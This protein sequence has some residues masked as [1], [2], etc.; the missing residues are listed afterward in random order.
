LS[1]PK[2]ASADDPQT[3]F[4]KAVD[5][6]DAGDHAAARDVLLRI[7]EQVP[8]HP[9]I[10]NYLGTTTHRTG[11][12]SSAREYF[13]R[14]VA[15]RPDFEEAWRNLGLLAFDMGDYAG[16]A[17]ALDRLCRLAPRDAQARTW[18]A[19]ALQAQDRCADAVAAYERA[20]E[21]NPLP[22]DT[23]TKMG[24]ALLWE[25]RWD[26]AC[27]AT[28]R[29]LDLR[30]G[31]TGALAL[32]SV[33]LA[34][35]G[36]RAEW[37][38]IVDFDRLLHSCPVPVPAGYQD[39][40]T[41]NEALS[42]YCLG[43]PTL[44]FNPISK[45]TEKGYQTADLARDEGPIRDLIAAIGDCVKGYTT[46]RPIVPNHP[47]LAQ[48]PAAW[49]IE[50]WGTV[51]GRQGH[52]SSHI[53]RDGW[54]SGVYYARV[55]DVLRDS[56]GDQAGWIEFGRPQ[57]YPKARTEPEVRRCRPVEGQIYLFPSYFYHRTIPFEAD[58][59]RISIAF[60]LIPAAE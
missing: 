45:T 58:V 56:D 46:D 34:E 41:F 59:Q 6:F 1:N 22:S 51:L 55:P 33:A 24:R 32:R 18:L 44:T 60:D 8:D 9:D 49:S 48:R 28:G 35:L 12:A 4:A 47:F 2:D 19:D 53:H 31:H 50:I 27:D 11:D 7:L 36:K 13:E 14:A 57:P 43:H 42:G 16:A 30:P 21:L 29:A 54:L 3:L 40:A 17:A 5:H 26:A 23:W 52:Q 10:L 25:G 38:E 20:L 39:M 37:S 15:V